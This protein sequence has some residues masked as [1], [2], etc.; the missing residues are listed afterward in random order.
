MTP[1]PGTKLGPYEIL[2]LIGAGGMGEVY[3]AR[4][5]R[6]DRIVALKVSKD[7]FSERFDREARSVAA[8]NH[9]N[10]CALYDVGPNYLVM[11][12]VEGETLAGPLPLETAVKYA[13]QI[14]EAVE[15]AHEKGIVHRDLKP[16]NVKVTPEGTV[17]VLDFGLAKA[18]S[19]D[20][21][22]GSVQNSP[23][24]SMAMTQAG[25]IL[26]TAAYMSPEQAKGKPADRRA[27]IWAFG[28]VFYEMLAGGQTFSGETAAETLASVLKETISFDRLPA[29]TPPAIRLLLARCLERDVRKRLQAIGEARIML[30]GPM[31][32]GDSGTEVP[33]QAEARSTKTP[34]AIAGV[35]A[36]AL[37]GLAAWTWWPRPKPVEVGAVHFTVAPPEGATLTGNSSNATQVSVSPDGHYV[38]FVA[39]ESGRGRTLWV[40]ALGSLSAQQLDRTEGARFPFWSP[41]SQTIAFFADGKL[42]RIPVS[43]GSPLVICDAPNPDGGTWNREG[44]IVFAPDANSPLHRVPAAGGV[45]TPVTTLDKTQQETAH[46]WPQFLPGGQRFLYWAGGTKGGIY[47]QSLGSSQRT[48]LLATPGRAVFASG[49][50]LF[51][52]D[53]TLL[54]QHLDLKSLRLEGEPVSVAEDIRS[55]ASNGRNGFSISENGV[56][57]YRSGGTSGNVQVSW[58][59]REGKPAGTALPAGD[60]PQIELSP[61]DKRLVVE[62][63]SSGSGGSGIDLWLLDLATGVFSRLT[64]G[65]DSERD[66]L[67]SPDSHSVIYTVPDGKE[68]GI[69]QVV[70]G[71]ADTPVFADGKANQLD[72][73]SRDGKL[74]VYHTQGG[75]DISILP[76]SGDRKPKVVFPTTFQKNQVRLSPDGRW[77]AYMSLESGQPEVYLAAFPS[78]TDRRQVSAGGGL[79]PR[80]QKDGRELYYIAFDRRVMA[81]EIK[82]GS[83]LETGAIKQL[84]R[85][86]P[87]TAISSTGYTWA[88]T[89][90]GQKFLIREV[91]GTTNAGAIEPIHIVI[92]WPAGL[93]R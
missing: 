21:V 90:D 60:Y 5:T 25:M 93:G 17:K 53:S 8:L 40:R 58:Y 4:D 45:S 88:V 13:R 86:Q 19:D 28:V 64:S 69:R 55:G 85:L 16:A 31:P 15:A 73:W 87:G 42:K 83:T 59:T 89:S 46:I 52:R 12:F 47:V 24:L 11:E 2:D 9:P 75:N 78:F 6:L 3:R 20:P 41:D 43:G 50:L 74:L 10:I 54:A 39:D 67:W 35:L 22:P 72:D 51:L 32:V 38:A 92:D 37:A 65:P 82:A 56:L 44:V 29:D 79:M 14:A 66:P 71:A 62:R 61:D 27:D 91:A 70:I 36:L 80:W 1:T 77:V 48:F 84:F 81:V 23:T 34:W 18:L 7:Q 76:L 30:E 63:T 33:L 49:F 57:A 26:G 68:P